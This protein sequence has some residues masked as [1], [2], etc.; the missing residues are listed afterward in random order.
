MTFQFSQSQLDQISA[1][2]NAQAYADAYDLK[3]R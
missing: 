1:L 2:Q 3:L